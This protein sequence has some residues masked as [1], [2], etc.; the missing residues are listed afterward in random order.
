MTLHWHGN[1]SLSYLDHSQGYVLSGQRV[2]WLCW[3]FQCLGFWDTGIWLRFSESQF[4][5]REGQPAPACSLLWV[6]PDTCKLSQPF[7]R[8]PPDGTALELWA[9]RSPGALHTPLQRLRPVVVAAW[10]I[11]AFGEITRPQGE[12]LKLLKKKLKEEEKGGFLYRPA[13]QL[14]NSDCTISDF[15][16]E[17][18]SPE[19]RLKSLYHSHRKVQRYE[20]VLTW[21]EMNACAES[22]GEGEAY[23]GDGGNPRQATSTAST[24]ASATLL[25]SCQLCTRNCPMC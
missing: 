6:S 22:Y 8:Q 18:M 12:C 13:S 20:C 1:T 7:L 21:A 23:T 19:G 4:C 16:Y 3:F 5:T 2:I 10:A 25:H 14:R 24:G 9:C 17:W 11:A 15:P